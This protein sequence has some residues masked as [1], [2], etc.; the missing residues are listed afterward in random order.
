MAE[1][2]LYTAEDTTDSLLDP[3]R[4]GNPEGV[5]VLPEPGVRYEYE[6]RIVTLLGPLFL[7]EPQGGVDELVLF[8]DPDLSITSFRIQDLSGKL[9]M[10]VR[11]IDGFTAYELTGE[12]D[13]PFDGV[14][15]ARWA[16]FNGGDDRITGTRAQDFLYGGFGADVITGGSGDDV[17]RGGDGNDTINGGKGNDSLYSGLGQNRLR[18]GKGFDLF[19]LDDQG[20]A[21]INGFKVQEDAVMLASPRS[22]YSVNPKADSTEIIFNPTGARVAELPGIASLKGLNLFFD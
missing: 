14:Q 8:F 9:L 17:I 1:I 3:W 10:E 6:G 7:N 20:F 5:Q 15:E 19:V 18:G 21:V 13:S 16:A 4:S 11:G 22:S 2:R 12:W